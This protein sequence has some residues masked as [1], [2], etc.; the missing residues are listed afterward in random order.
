VVDFVGCWSAKTEI[1][2][3][4]LVLWLAIGLSKFYDWAKGWGGGL[5]SAKRSDVSDTMMMA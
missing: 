5:R 3:R 1:A 4:T 2:I